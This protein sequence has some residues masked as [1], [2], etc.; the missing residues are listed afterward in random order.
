MR[1][2][3]SLAVLT[4]LALPAAAAAQGDPMADA[5]RMNAADF[6][7]NLLASAR[8]MPA[9]KYGFKP[10][11]AEMSFGQ[12]I[13]HIA[14]DNHVTCSAIAGV[15]PEPRA[16]VTAADGKEKLVAALQ[17]SLDEC[18]AALKDLKDAGMGDT[19]TYYG[20]RYPRALAVMGLLIDWS[21]HYAQQAIYLRLN[22]VLPPTARRGGGM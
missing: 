15:K 7:K 8:L 4:L 3:R 16:K 22:G 12:L 13:A 11:P 6:A 17:G 14:G 5:A 19:V 2:L 10:T 20:Q 9:E 18:N 21:D 1:A